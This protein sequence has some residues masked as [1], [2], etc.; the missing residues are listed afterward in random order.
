MKCIGPRAK[1]AGLWIMIGE[2]MHRVHQ[3]GTLVEVEHVQAQRSEKEKQQVSLFEK[4]FAE[5]ERADEPAKDG[6]MVEE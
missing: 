5:D 3:E 6:A 2:E 1:D 4:F